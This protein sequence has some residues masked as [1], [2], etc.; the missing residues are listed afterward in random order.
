MSLVGRCLVDA[1]EFLRIAPRLS[2]RFSVLLNAHAIR[3]SLGCF[4][5]LNRTD[6]ASRIQND[7][8]TAYDYIQV[9]GSENVPFFGDDFW[10][11][12]YVLE[13]LVT[14]VEEFSDSRRREPL[15]QDLKAF[16][17]EVQ[18]CLDSGL[19]VGTPEEWFG[20]AIPTA[21]FRL[22]TR[23]KPYLEKERGVEKCLKKLK[24][25][26]LERMQDHMYRGRPVRPAY[27]HW[28]IG[29]VIAQFPKEARDQVEQ[30]LDFERTVTG[31]TEP[32]DRA[33][34]LARVIQGASAV[35][36]E[37]A[38]QKALSMLYECQT[39]T[40]PLGTGIVGYNVKASLNTL[41]A[42]WPTLAEG[43]H[44]QINSMLDALLAARRRVKRIGIL[45]ALDRERD[46][47]K[48]AFQKDGAKVHPKDD[49]VL[50]V[51][52]ADYLVVIIKGKALLAA[53]EATAKLIE[54]HRVTRAITVGIA[55]S[56]GQAVEDGKFRGPGKG[57]VVIATSTAAYRV[58]ET[59]RDEVKS[60]PVP[61]DQVTW[62]VLPTDTK[63]FRLG[64]RVRKQQLPFEVH[65]GLI[66]TGN[67]VKDNPAE[68]SRI[69]Q[70]WPG[71]LAVA[72]EGFAAAL[73]CALHDVPYIEIRG[74][75]DMA[76]GDKKHQKAV[77]EQEERDQRRAAENAARIA[78]QLVRNLAG[79]F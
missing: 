32:S 56:L 15:Q 50:E 35:R 5:D 72:E 19:A 12:A 53:T 36:E 37:T 75:S 52:H 21:A 67:G 31:L 58:R 22:L 60:E 40:C 16:Y 73:E 13:A 34:A 7:V 20:P 49:D 47:C 63:L 57:D 29:Q 9:N 65:E 76:E 42:L 23:S 59:V 66:L 33:Y 78:V 4:K 6:V 18:R 61:F 77:P 11:W 55:G 28:H 68:K 64:H 48:D 30:L 8:L 54:K 27:Y 24:S 25:L 71:G 2:T 38:F 44:V 69:R 79:I 74:I 10:D 17:G 1:L 3:L 51:E 70:E 41:E 43:D 45:V 26:A 39:K 46:V 62:T 14:V